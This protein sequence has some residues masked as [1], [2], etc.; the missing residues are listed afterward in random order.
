MGTGTTIINHFFQNNYHRLHE[1][2][3]DY[4]QRYQYD[5]MSPEDMVSGYYMHVFENENRIHKLAVLISIT[6][7]TNMW[8][9]ENKAW[10]YI[11]RIYYRLTQGNRT[12]EKNGNPDKLDLVFTDKLF[13]TQSLESEIGRFDHLSLDDI[14]INRET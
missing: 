4:S 8:F 14:R 13:P 7:N 10:F 2:C 1:L 9:Y 12:F 11:A 6:A 5:L 3:L